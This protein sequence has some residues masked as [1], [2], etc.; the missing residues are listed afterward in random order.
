MN[1]NTFITPEFDKIMQDA[2]LQENQRELSEEAQANELITSSVVSS[3]KPDISNLVDAVIDGE[4]KFDVG[5]RLMIESYSTGINPK[6]WLTTQ[7]FIV[8][9]LNTETGD[10]GLFNPDLRQSAFTNYKKA[11]LRGDVL[12]FEAVKKPRVVIPQP[13]KWSPASRS[14]NVKIGRRVGTK[15]RPKDV[16]KAERDAYNTRKMERLKKKEEKLKSKV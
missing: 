12:K 3:L 7:V 14:T 2:Q 9:S 16:V 1:E 13:S 4:P 15:N 10:V 5:D 6:R 11:P 8:K